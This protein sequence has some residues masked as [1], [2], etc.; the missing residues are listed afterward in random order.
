MRAGRNPQGSLSQLNSDCDNDG[1]DGGGKFDARYTSSMRGARN[2]MNMAENKSSTAAGSTH[3][4]NNYR[5]SDTHNSRP[6][7][8]R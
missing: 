7:I 4:D 6:E 1:D 3:R 8:Q 5:T 2:N